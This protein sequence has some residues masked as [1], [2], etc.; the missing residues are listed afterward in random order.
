LGN[1]ERRIRRLQKAIQAG[2]AA[3]AILFY[4]RDILYYSGTAQPAYLMVLPDDYALFVRSGMDFVLRECPLDKDRIIAE[5]NIVNACRRMFPGQGAGQ[6]VGTELDRLT[7][8]QARGLQS[9]LRDRELVDFTPMVLAQRMV[10]DPEET[11]CVQLACRAVHEGHLAAV[12]CLHP[13]ITE[14]ELAVRVEDAQRLAGHAGVFFLRPPDVLMGRGPVA[15]GPNLREISGVILTITG[16][17]LDAA[18]PVG[19]SRRVIERGDLVLVD[20][21]ACVGGYHADQTRMYCVGR[22]AEEALWLFERLREVA[23]HLIESLRPGMTCDAAFHMARDRA[24]AVGIGKWFM[25]FPSGAAAHFIGHGIGLEMNEPPILRKGGSDP[26]DEGTVFTLE[27]HV[28][29]PGGTVLKLEDT[30]QLSSGGCRIL[31]L[32]PREIITVPDPMEGT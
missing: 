14:L 12:S 2:D 23:D 18:V 28:T 8:L 32:S 10:K 31:T 29:H 3:G 11:Q 20:I 30:V 6:K 7:V 17:G 26:L 24:H 1:Y 4:S 5:R 13:G 15:S 19:P 21:P 25:T 16:V 9:A 22:P 27:M